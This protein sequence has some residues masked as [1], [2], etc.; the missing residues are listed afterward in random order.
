MDAL[1]EELARYRTKYAR[2]LDG[3]WGVLLEH[4]DPMSPA[5]AVWQ[6]HGSAGSREHRGAQ[7][8]AFT[9]TF[10]EPHVVELDWGNGDQ[11]RIPYEFSIVHA[12]TRRI[13]LTARG[14]STFSNELGPLVLILYA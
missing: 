12:G 4:H 9:C 14:R 10:P 3:R 2:N 6:F 8:E 5:Y 13:A 1:D 7:Y 11:E